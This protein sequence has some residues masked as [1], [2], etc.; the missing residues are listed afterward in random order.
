MYKLD[1]SFYLRVKEKMQGVWGKIFLVARSRSFRKIA[2]RYKGF[3][4]GR[5]KELLE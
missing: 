2:V 1:D 3:I 4:D 5:Y